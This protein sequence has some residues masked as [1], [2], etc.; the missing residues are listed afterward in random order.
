MSRNI[1][2]I[3]LAV[4]AFVAVIVLILT[5]GVA[6]AGLIALLA[7]AGCAVGFRRDSRARAARARRAGPRRRAR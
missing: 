3:D 7:L 6:V 4:A 2:L 1:L 5:P